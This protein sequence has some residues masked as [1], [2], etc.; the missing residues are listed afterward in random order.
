MLIVP[1]LHKRRDVIKSKKAT[2]DTVVLCPLAENAPLVEGKCYDFQ[3]VAQGLDPDEYQKQALQQFSV[4]FGGHPINLMR[5]CLAHQLEIAEAE[6]YG[7]DVLTQL[8]NR[9]S[10]LV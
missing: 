2:N 6:N 8:K 1:P 4:F 3:A 9:I 7:N 5:A 10:E